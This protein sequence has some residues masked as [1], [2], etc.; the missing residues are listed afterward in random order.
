MKTIKLT[1]AQATIKYLSA[2]YNDDQQR[3]LSGCWAIFGHGNVAA[4]GEA[5]YH[6]KEELPT[7]RGHNEQTMA[8]AAIAYAKALNR[9]RAMAVTT[10]IGPGA[11][12]LVTAAALA[13]VNRLPVLFLPGDVFANRQPDP[14][15][16]QIECFSDGTVSANDSFKPVSQYFDRITR[17][18]QLLTALPRAMATMTDPATCGPVTLAFCQDTQAQAYDFP[19]SFFE[20]KIWHTRR[21][22]PDKNELKQAIEAIKQAKNPIIIAGGGVLY[23]EACQELQQFAELLNI[24]VSETQ[25]GKSALAWDHHLNF[26][27]IGVTGASAA[28]HVAKD[29]DLVIAIGTRLQDF[30]TGS[31]SLF[32]NQKILSINVNVYDTNK[33]SHLAVVGDAKVCLKKLCQ[34]LSGTPVKR[35]DENLRTEWLAEI[36]QVTKA[37]PNH[38][39]PTDAQ[40]IGAV[41][42]NVDENAILVGAAGGLPGE[43]HKIWKAS[44]PNGYHMEYGY[45]CMG[46]EIAGAVGVKMAYPERDVVVMVGDGSYLMHNSELATSVMLGQKIIVVVL[47]NRGFACINRLQNATGGESFNNL[48]DTAYHVEPSQVDFC[49]HAA[50][51]GAN[52]VKV[53]LADLPNA[54]QNARQVTKTSVIVIDTEPVQTSNI[55]GWWWNVAVPEVST[56]SQVNEAF[57]NYIYNS[58][59]EVQ[60]DFSN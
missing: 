6:A 25:A 46:Y 31:W 49:K 10:S 35:C 40:V 53:S 43:L 11:T 14:V 56:R 50:S 34:K 60:T 17:P 22:R 19:V 26:G 27:A 57:D 23:S 29:A 47:D 37:N 20:N 18:E 1:A 5:L 44:K 16:Q 24:P 8:F 51:L 39:L 9:K 15:L 2:Q 45:S 30:T 32:Q 3:F 13:H 33:H 41:Q 42:A 28:N 21:I 12:N 55:G 54:I 4:L 52:A 38:E 59:N 58:R 36:E 48:L 7:Y